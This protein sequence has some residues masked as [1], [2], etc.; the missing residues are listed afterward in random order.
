[1][2]QS[3]NGMLRRAN[4]SSSDLKAQE[5]NRTTSFTDVNGNRVSSD[6]Y[7]AACAAIGQLGLMSLYETMFKNFNIETSQLLVTAFDFTSEER[8]SNIQYVIENLLGHNII[9][10]I[11][12]NDAVTGNQVYEF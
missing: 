1:M 10:I 9:P 8:R 4:L 3:V 12:E 2:N 11:N 5:L 6:S 7:N